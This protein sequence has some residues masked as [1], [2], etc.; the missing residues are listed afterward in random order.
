M[1]MPLFARPFSVVTLA[2]LLLTSPLTFAADAPPAPVK[3]VRVKQTTIAPTINIMATL[4]SQ[5]Q[6]QI[7]A[8]IN[9]QLT[10]VAEPGTYL[11]QGEPVAKMDLI[12]LKLQLAEEQAQVDR[13]K[14]NVNYQSTELARLEKLKLQDNASIFQIDQTKSRRDLAKS[15]MKIAKLRVQQTRDQ[16]NRAVIVAP[17]NGVVTERLRH[18]GE[19][20]NRS[21]LIARMLD[22]Q[23]LEARLFVP[24]KHLAYVKLGDKL[25]LST[26]EYQLESQVNAII[27]SADQRS[28]TFELRITI[29]PSASNYWA[30]GQLVNVALPINKSRQ[31]LAVH[32]DA[33]II[34]RDGIY[35]IRIG[36]DNK[37]QRVKVIV[38]D[39]DEEWVSVSGDLKDGDQ[40]AIR[41]AERLQDGQVVEVHS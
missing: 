29:D 16:L 6:I 30:A 8:A 4:F 35:V 36:E 17:Y 10:W 21:I 5:H 18:A 37:A 41:G 32:R 7:T 14:I 26:N 25:A 1:N 3:T 24:L 12:P 27:P 22:T 9:G 2:C 28:Q 23:H 13:A 11:T 33:L 31:S 39:G 38:G 34:R 20:V 15:D 40:V 19:D